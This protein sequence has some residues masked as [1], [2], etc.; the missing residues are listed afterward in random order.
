MRRK[1]FAV[2]AGA[3]VVVSSIMPLA[4]SAAGLIT[5]ND[6]M[7]RL[8]LDPSFGGVTGRTD[9][10]VTLVGAPT[11]RVTGNVA[12]RSRGVRLV[13]EQTALA[14]DLKRI[15]PAARI[16]GRTRVASNTLLVT[17]DMAALERLAADP[18]VARV[19]RPR[20]FHVDLSETV[21]Y[22][23]ARRV[24]AGANP[25]DGTGIVVAI[26]DSGIDYTHKAF[27]G[28]GTQAAY[29]AAYGSRSGARQSK[30]PT[31]FP[32]AKVIAGYD[33]VG[34]HWPERPLAADPDPIDC[35]PDLF[36]CDGGHGTHVADI[37]AG[38]TSD[39][40]SGVAPGASLMAVKVCSAVSSACSHIAIMQ[41]IDFALD[42]DGDAATDDAADVIN[43]SLGSDYGGSSPDDTEIAALENA[44][45][46]GVLVVAASGNGGDK[47]Y[48]SGSPASAPSTISVAQTEVP[49]ALG[50]SMLVDGAPK[51]AVPQDWSGTLTSARTGVAQYADGAGG[52]L[53]GCTAFAAGSLTGKIV[54]VDRGSCTFTKKIANIAA[55]GGALGIIALIAAGDPFSGSFA[56]EDCGGLCD[57]IPGY[58][59]SLENGA[60]L[61]SGATVSFDPAN[62]FALVGTVVGSSSRGP[63]S[64]SNQV[65]PEIG[66]PGA[67][68]SAVVGSGTGTSSFGGTSGA[69]P[70]VAGSA[71]IVRAARPGLTPV[72]VKA[73][74]MNTAETQIMN[75]ASVLG[76]GLASIARIGGGEVRVDKAVATD[77]IA[78]D[79]DRPTAALSFGFHD[80][81][82][83]TLTLTRRVQLDNLSASAHSYSAAS[84]F[85]FENDQTNG[86]VSVSISQPGQ[87][88][89]G[90][91][92]S[93][94]VTLT[95]DASKLR[96][97][98]LD[99]GLR[100]ADTDALALLE[101]DGYITITGGN[102]SIHLPWHVL[103][104]KAGAVTASAAS[105]AAGGDVTL[106]N[107][108]AGRAWLSD[109]DL[110][111]ESERATPS[112]PTDDLADVDIRYV[113]IRQ[114]VGADATAGLGCSVPY[115]VQFAITTWDRQVSALVPGA[116]Q[117]DLKIGNGPVDLS[118]YDADAAGPGTLDD[119]RSFTWVDV[120]RA[121]P[122]R[123]FP[124][125]HP[126]NASNFVL[127]VCG[128]DI[129][130]DPRTRSGSR[131]FGRTV[132]ASIYAGDIYYSGALRDMVT[133]TFVLGA[134]RFSVRDDGGAGSLDWSALSAGGTVDLTVDALTGGART[135][136]DRVLILTDHNLAASNVGKSGGASETTGAIVLDVT[137]G[138]AAAAS[139]S[140]G[141]TRGLRPTE[142][143]AIA[144]ARGLGVL[145]RVV[146]DVGGRHR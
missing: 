119:G 118:I 97:W 70:M 90:N 32:T 2:L 53:N 122:A 1:L 78:Y 13:A 105:V 21:P 3:T 117:V 128:E 141:S 108:G 107:A 36:G 61:K 60:L 100:G 55:G 140:A 18:R 39:A 6:P 138:A 56:P 135:A 106:T 120:G 114:Y 38:I 80:V 57:T 74:L 75:K 126:T 112:G 79:Q 82:S 17:A 116:F 111:G 46:A 110:I 130:L 45:A 26:L 29:L 67:S 133:A 146:P 121:A 35:S 49:S 8:R 59:I 95:I 37:V 94:E 137:Q 40:S 123:A 12:Q 93:F 44:T 65:K 51:E 136:T 96:E 43:L 58:M 131:T 115:G 81:S 89:G 11:A 47:P 129:G 87:V 134:D 92:T 86:A 63:E 69:T 4:T 71:A 31:G 7:A 113:G 77:T 124:T 132:S 73:A 15:D 102:Q 22:I 145:M 62:A 28:L 9:A 25:T 142:A 33:F 101:Y 14:S 42:P 84:S 139:A 50:F 88:A 24:T 30:I 98:T 72:Q 10:I 27:G 99:S 19:S 16:I 64:Q 109:F 68:V 125:I 83:G 104:R 48:I 76:G 66:A 144:G 103:P 127:T 91:G 34:E 85:R 20:A 54:L 23:G 41:G 52:N 5:T 143:R